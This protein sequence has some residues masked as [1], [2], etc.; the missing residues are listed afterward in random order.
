M[1][2]SKKQ[3]QT[4][5]GIYKDFKTAEEIAI[6]V[7]ANSSDASTAN[8]NPD[9]LKPRFLELINL[10]FPQTPN[11]FKT[12]IDLWESLKRLSTSNANTTTNTTTNTAPADFL[13]QKIRIY[14]CDEV[15][16]SSSQSKYESEIKEFYKKSGRVSAYNYYEGGWKDDKTLS[17]I[18]KHSLSEAR[19][20]S[21]NK[22]PKLTMVL[23]DTPAIDIKLRN[24]DL[25]SLFMNYMPSVMLTQMTP[26]LTVDFSF[27]RKILA[28]NDDRPLTTMSQLKFLLGAQEINN[29]PGDF[30]SAE[31]L[32]YDALYKKKIAIAAQSATTPAAVAGR[33]A[34]GG[35]AVPGYPPVSSSPQQLES[36]TTTT[37]MDL[38]TMPQTLI[39]MDYDQSVTP[40]Y[41]P[42]LNQT[43]PFGTITNLTMNVTPSVGL[44]S[45]KTATLTL[46]IFDRSRLSEI[47]DFINPRLYKKTTIWLT[48]GWRAP[49]Q[50]GL[51]S[52]DLNSYFELINNHMLKREAY[53]VRNSG[54]SMESDGTA[55]VTLSLYTKGA[56]ELNSISPISN[57]ADFEQKLQE[58]DD[59]LAQIKELAEKIGLGSLSSGSKDVRGSQVISAALSGAIPQLDVTTLNKELKKID[60]ALQSNT[61]PDVARFKAL[62]KDT[63]SLSGNST[64]IKAV[65]DLEGQG[66]SL[67]AAR[68]NALKNST[69]DFFIQ[70]DAEKFKNDRN[71]NINHPLTPKQNRRSQTTAENVSFARLFA[72]YFAPASAS[73]SKNIIDEYQIIFYN[74]NNLAGKVANVNIGEF[75]IDVGELEK[76]Y[77]EK[78]VEQRGEEMSLVNFLEL[79]RDSQFSNPKHFAYGNADLYDENG[80]LLEGKDTELIK[81]NIENNNLGKAFVPPALDFYLE[82]SQVSKDNNVFHDL[83][84]SFEISASIQASG[85]VTALAETKIMRI[86]IY[87]KAATPHSTA[88][89]II[90][91]GD[92][93][94][95]TLVEDSWQSKFRADE[96]SVLNN[97]NKEFFSNRRTRI[98]ARINSLSSSSETLSFGKGNGDAKFEEV[99]RVIAKAVPTILVGSNGTTIKNASF[100]TNQD[101]LLSTI[102]MRRNSTSDE[103]VSQ[104]NGASTFDL[105]LQVIP[106]QL[107]LT[108]LGCPLLEYMQQYFVDLHTGTNIDA[109][110]NIT[111]LTHNLSPGQFTSEIK[112][113]FADGYGA[114]QSPLSSFKDLTKIAEKISEDVSPQTQSQQPR[115]AKAKP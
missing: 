68:F 103:S 104:K 70:S 51:D 61:S 39:N 67:A 77:A 84:T 11:G 10:L 81:R 58:F 91:D 16:A 52:N 83:L 26:Y 5:R 112:F 9:E 40:R 74:L 88:Y 71:K 63:Y 97:N 25:V 109:L 3:F 78:V 2:S 54:I 66:K 41:H 20:P 37:G 106:G 89:S 90:K 14:Y 114:F 36:R 56:S 23:V 72:T 113:T 65:V 60:D 22:T 94:D 55:T 95:F 110:Y 47:A 4:L 45:F 93:K 86:H 64:K 69:V 49:S 76:A 29:P 79:V 50:I 96:V 92:A 53:G 13:I 99:K 102:M 115:R 73:S 6:D 19:V 107:S 98:D 101:S 48:Y 108:T 100:S 31:Q 33:L 7:F 75:P 62:I 59:K 15:S 28:T 46:K 8:I 35:R 57:T 43:V 30:R 38:F 32:I 42:V 82:T 27:D 21:D 85:N 17:D 12:G 44:F 18:I 80:K 105:P 34:T 87:D 24:T 111:S 1:P